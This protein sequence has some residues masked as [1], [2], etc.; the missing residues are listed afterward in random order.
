[1]G[2]KVWLDHWIWGEWGKWP[3]HIS[4]NRFEK[5]LALWGRS[6][7]HFIIRN[8]LQKQE[9]FF[10]GHFCGSLYGVRW[11]YKIKIIL[12]SSDPSFP[13]MWEF[14]HLGPES[15][16]G[17]YCRRNHFYRSKKFSIDKTKR[18]LTKRFINHFFRGQFCCRA[19][20]SPKRIWPEDIFWSRIQ[21]MLWLYSMF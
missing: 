12:S 13:S 10:G 14:L 2:F 17:N 1:M 6:V 5:Q 21:G 8:W 9:R 15:F 18:F 20:F 4:E 16:D 3:C 7:C 19:I 11:N